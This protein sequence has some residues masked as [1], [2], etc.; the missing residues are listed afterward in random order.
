MS[1]KSGFISIDVIIVFTFVIGLSFVTMNSYRN[2]MRANSNN[3]SDKAAENE[4]FLGSQIATAYTSNDDGVNVDDGWSENG[5]SGNQGTNVPIYNLVEKIQTEFPE[6]EINVGEEI[7]NLPVHVYPLNATK[8]A[9]SWKVISGK[10]KTLITRD[11]KGHSGRVTGL[12]SGK[13]A[14]RFMAT[15]GSD[16]SY[17][18][19][20][21]VNQPVTGLTLDREN[22]TIT[23]S[24]TG[25]QSVTVKA[26]VKPDTGD[27]LA[28]NTRVSWSFGNG[29]M[30]SECLSMK[31]NNRNNTVTITA[32]NNYCHGGTASIIAKTDDGGFQKS[33]KVR[34]N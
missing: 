12:K 14:L 31:P 23:L 24:L 29:G 17:T 10:D 6:Y 30:N 5:S 2:N 15:D 20:I 4:T 33:F 27:S 26:T 22:E 3:I 25:T 34:V 9:L 16:V 32:I 11:D 7:E 1:K 28:S 21:S 18:I 19:F 8:D 13:T